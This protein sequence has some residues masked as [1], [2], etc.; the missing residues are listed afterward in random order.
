MCWKYEMVV[1]K[2]WTY[3][4]TLLCAALFFMWFP[5][6]YISYT[7]LIL[8]VVS[9]QENITAPEQRKESERNIAWVW[10]V[11]EYRTGRCG[12]SAQWRG[13]KQQHWHGGE[14]YSFVFAFLFCCVVLLLGHFVVVLVLN[15]MYKLCLF[16]SV[17]TAKFHCCV[18]FF[19]LIFSIACGSC[20][21]VH[22]LFGVIALYR[23]ETLLTLQ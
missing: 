16:N 13:Q 20:P 22:R 1:M 3:E 21:C 8:Q 6:P 10:S 17:S 14:F 15:F 11:Y 12:G 23:W 19:N 5:F 4:R 9:G 7:I 2:G 18:F